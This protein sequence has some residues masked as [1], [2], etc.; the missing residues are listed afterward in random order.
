[1]VKAITVRQLGG[2]EVLHFE[3]VKIGNPGEG[4]I[5]LRQSVAG[6]NFIDTYHRSGIYPAAPQENRPKRSWI[7]SRA[8]N[9]ENPI[10]LRL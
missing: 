1:M 4:E 5:R 8:R 3:D 6:V 9:Q 10:S 7:I 2:P